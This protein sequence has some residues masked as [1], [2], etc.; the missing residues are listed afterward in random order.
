MTF[1]EKLLDVAKKVH[2]DVTQLF[3]LKLVDKSKVAFCIV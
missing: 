1:E 3:N 2:K